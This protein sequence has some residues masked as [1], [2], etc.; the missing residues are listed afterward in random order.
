MSVLQS[1]LATFFLAPGCLGSSD[2][3][4]L[5]GVLSSLAVIVDVV[6]PFVVKKSDG[7]RYHTQNEH[8]VAPVGLS[9]DRCAKRAR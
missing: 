7:M 2:F 8:S 5:A 9:G 4:F 6:A 1:C 3:G